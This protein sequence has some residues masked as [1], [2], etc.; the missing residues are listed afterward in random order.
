M[1][2][3]CQVEFQMICQDDVRVYRHRPIQKLLQCSFAEQ[4]K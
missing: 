1:S 2:E 3:K 4:M